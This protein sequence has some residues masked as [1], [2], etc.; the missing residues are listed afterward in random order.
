[1]LRRACDGCDGDG[2]G[3]AAA[4]AALYCVWGLLRLC[5]ALRRH[6][7]AATLRA[8]T[9]T[10]CEAVRA[11]GGC[12]VD[13]AVGGVGS[14]STDDDDGGGGGGGG[15]AGAGL[16]GVRWEAPWVRAGQLDV[17]RAQLHRLRLRA[18]E[19]ATA[20]CGPSDEPTTDDDN[21]NS[22]AAQLSSKRNPVPWVDV[23]DAVLSTA[24]PGDE[25]TAAATLTHIVVTGGLWSSLVRSAVEAAA[26]AGGEDGA[27]V[28]ALGEADVQ[29]MTAALWHSF[30]AQWALPGGGERVSNNGKEEAAAGPVVG[31]RLPAPV[32]WMLRATRA[33]ATRVKLRR[34]AQTLGALVLMV[35]MQQQRSR[36]AAALPRRV[37]QRAVSEVYL[38]DDVELLSH[39]AV[40]ALLQ[41]LE[42][43]EAAEA[44]EADTDVQRAEQLA[45]FF[46]N[47][48]YGE[49]LFA[50]RVTRLLR[51]CVP[52]DVRLATWRTL[53]DEMGL[54]LLPL[55]PPPEPL[56]AFLPAGGESSMLMLHALVEAMEMGS[57]DRAIRGHSLP[58]LIA[59]RVVSE[60]GEADGCG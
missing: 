17:G 51:G 55:P 30:C 50:A 9:R 27:V 8:V 57:L 59:V 15:V 35:A 45:N 29:Q 36:V 49:P 43:A 47:V 46:C 58:A 54:H 28:A 53:T 40:R 19:A 12:M 31:S 42:A 38:A 52:V 39:H 2:S 60:G 10:A 1:M 25:A 37:T 5:G 32:G 24:A 4:A 16:K 41:L 14:G 13:R 26:A 23:C 6:A 21:D 48:S 7:D 34:R 3:V 33:G 18:L 56:A 22:G 44:A 11:I 20:L